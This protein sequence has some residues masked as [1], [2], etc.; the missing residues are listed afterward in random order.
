MNLLA[1]RKVLILEDEVVL[2]LLLED[3]LRELG[4]AS[5]R[6]VS[7]L[8]EATT[9]IG[10]QPFDAAILDVNIHGQMS[11][12]VADRLAFAG[13]PSVFVSGYAREAVPARLANVPFIRKPYVLEDICG[14]LTRVLGIGAI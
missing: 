7:S 4:V 8:D 10:A 2:A 12:P 13:V 3:M 11:Y 1:G 14:A 6:H 9:V 5:V